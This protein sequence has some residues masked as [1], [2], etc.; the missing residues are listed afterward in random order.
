MFRSGMFRNL[1]LGFGLLVIVA[2][3]LLGWLVAAQAERN[4]VQSLKDRL[5]SEAQILREFLR[6]EEP[7]KSAV[8]RRIQQL[9]RR[10]VDSR[11]TLIAHDGAVLADSQVPLADLDNHVNREEVVQAFRDPSGVGTAIRSSSTQ[12]SDLMYLA[13]RVDR[14][15][16]PYVVRVSLPVTMLRQ[17]VGA[18]TRLVWVTAALTGLVALGLAYWLANR[19]VRPLHELIRGAEQIASGDYGH[20]VFAGDG[21]EVGILSRSFNHMSERLAAQFAQIDEDRQQL[22]TVLSSMV[23]GVI[24]VDPDQKIL[25]ANDRAGEL[26]GF[27]PRTAVGRHLWELIRQRPLQTVIQSALAEDDTQ[28]QTLALNL[29][30][31]RSFAVQVARLPGVRPRAAVLVFHDNTALRRLER[32]RQEFVA[33]VS[34][35]LKT[36]LAIIKVC[37]ETLIDGGVDDPVFRDRSLH[38]VADQTERLHNLIIDLL[39]LARIES[40]T[41][42]FTMEELDLGEL[43]TRCLE[44]SRSLAESKR[45]SLTTLPPP[46]GSPPAL[47]WID[48]EAADQILENL[49]NN[50]IKYTPEGGRVTVRCGVEGDRVVLEV[51]DT[52]IGIPEAELPRIFERFYRVDKARSR[53]L[54]GTGLGLSIVK[55]LVGAMQ[56]TV[57]AE[58]TV[59]IGSTFTIHFP[60]RTATR[61]PDSV[62]VRST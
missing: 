8:V 58:S 39:R 33:N 44:R 37:V 30:G 15:D 38:R 49:V 56:G 14:P 42:A 12:N 28:H 26:L 17:R 10:D 11:V 16:Q 45:M 50:A 57:R 9:P 3:A 53:E 20:R 29:P 62:E 7:D 27:N 21:A 19:I 25:F 61:V 1:F 24:A 55:H 41:E 2:V 46:V 18:L 47:V 40:E 5:L 48:E 13:L 54:G 6:D 59:G 43:A 4:A 60:A 31:S 52:G 34:H 36:P 35:E 23:E 22:R 32:L 51:S